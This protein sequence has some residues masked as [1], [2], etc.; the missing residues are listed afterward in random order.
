MPV[1]QNQKHERFA[2]KVVRG[3]TPLEAYTAVFGPSA[4]VPQNASRLRAREEVS[5]RIDELRCDLAAKLEAG[6]QPPEF[7]REAVLAGLHAEATGSENGGARVRAWELIN[8]N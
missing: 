8:D 5:A 7:S 1:L 3:M 6:K 4:S 2:A